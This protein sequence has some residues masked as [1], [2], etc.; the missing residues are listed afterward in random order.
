MRKE[1]GIRHFSTTELTR[2]YFTEKIVLITVQ[3]STDVVTK[4]DKVQLKTND[5][6]LAG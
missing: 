5:A 4:I 6:A 2:L 1:L 3:N